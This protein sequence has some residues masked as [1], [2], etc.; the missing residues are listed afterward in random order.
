MQ[1]RLRV[2]F[3]SRN[4]RAD[5][6]FCIFK[7]AR[8]ARL[9]VLSFRAQSQFNVP[10]P[11][12]HTDQRKL[13]AVMLTDMAAPLSTLNANQFTERGVIK[14]GVEKMINKKA[15]LAK[16]RRLRLLCRPASLNQ[17][18]DEI[19]HPNDE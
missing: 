17:A 4:S 8:R 15:T 11:S 2:D 7:C 3:T 5:R 12:E 6:S 10:V 1:L 16:V 9:S 19:R 13:A 18:N 14:P